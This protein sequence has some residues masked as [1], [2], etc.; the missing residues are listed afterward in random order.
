MDTCDICNDT[1]W[2]IYKENE[3]VLTRRCSKCY[4]KK[5]GVKKIISAL[6]P[7]RYEN[8]DFK[9]YGP[10]NSSQKKAKSIAMHFAEEYPDISTGL[11][12]M[13]PCGIG[14]SH[15]A[16]ATM[17]ELINKG[18]S[19]IF[20]DFRDLLKK[21]QY[22]YNIESGITE[23]EVLRPVLERDILVLDELGA[24]KVTSW[25]RDT[26]MHIINRRYNDNKV[27]IIT[28]NYMD[29]SPKTKDEEESLSDRIG[30]R[31]R[32]RLHEMCRVV[33]MDGKD[34][35]LTVKQTGLQNHKY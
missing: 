27:T 34:W 17:K 15:L 33:E 24:Q 6:I 1:G 7:S 5:C 22:S 18:F 29:V 9:G 20:Y 28:S 14:K 19:C 13:G 16:V 32:S 2:E 4:E 3:I 26:L 35:R 31:L 30:Y 10:Q 8:C 21:L 25:I 12:F 23:Y 11:L